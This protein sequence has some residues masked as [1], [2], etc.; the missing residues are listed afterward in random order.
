[1]VIKTE[2]V[3]ALSASD[4]AIATDKLSLAL[5]SKGVKEIGF[6]RQFNSKNNS[7]L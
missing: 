5:I 7:F 4:V 3:V 6:M 2:K 1:M